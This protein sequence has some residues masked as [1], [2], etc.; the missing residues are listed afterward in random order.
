MKFLKLISA[1]VLLY[2]VLNPSEIKAQCAS[3][4]GF[5]NGNLS[6][7]NTSTDSLYIQPA[8]RV[9]TNPGI[10]S[11]IVS[12]GIT[13]AWLGTVNSPSSQ[14]GSYMVKVGNRGLRAVSDTVYRTFVIDSLSDKLTIYS[15][16]VSEIAHVF[17]NVP[18]N[19]SPGFGYEIYMNGKKVDC[20][21]GA[22]FTGNTDL[23]HVWDL[24][25]YKDTA[26]IR[27]STS[28]GMEVFNL[29]CFV[30]DTIEIRLFT[31]DCILL[32]HYAYAYFDVVCGDTSK[33]PISKITVKDVIQDKE[34]VL[35]CT[36]NATIKLEPL[37]ETCPVYMGNIK[38]TPANYI[39][40]P[41]NLDSAI[42]NV[43]DSAWIYAEAEF[44]N[45]CMSVTILDSI[46]VRY[47]PIDPHDNLPKI[48]KNFC[49]CD[50]DTIN[51]NGIKVTTIWDPSSATYNLNSSNRLV[52]SPCDR[53]TMNTTWKN[54]SANATSTG[55]AI[56]QSSW[57]SGN[58]GG[59]NTV[60]S[61]LP[62]GR[63][64][65][66]V[67]LITGKRMFLG[68][69]HNQSSYNNDLRHS[70]YINGN[71]ITAYFGT[72]AT[73]SS[74][75]FS[76]SIT[77]EFEVLSN[78]R[79]RIYINGSVFHNYTTTQKVLGPVFGD[80]SAQ[81]NF[82]PMVTST[83]ITGATKNK[84]QIS[85]L[86]NL[87][88][89]QY[90]LSY[91]DR[92]GTSTLDTITYTPG[93]TAA[94][95]TDIIQ[96]G[97]TPV[98]LGVQSGSLIDSITYS[99]INASGSFSP[100]N[101][102]APSRGKNL[103]YNPHF[104]D[105]NFKPM[106]VIF[107]SFSGRC[108]TKDTV[109]MTVNE[110]PGAQAGA[111]ITVAND[112]FILGDSPSGICNTCGSLQYIWSQGNALNDSTVANPVAYKYQIGAPYFVLK[113]N[114]SI[115]GCLNI[116][117]IQIFTTLAAEASFLSNNC[118]D[119]NTVEVRWK[120]APDKDIEAFGVEYSTDDGFTWQKLGRVDA[121]DPS[122]GNNPME[123][124]LQVRK[125][126][127]QYAIYRWFAISPTG[128]SSR[129]SDLNTLECGNGNAFTLFPN[130]F[131]SNIEVQYHS[132]STVFRNLTVELINQYGQIV[133]S[134]QVSKASNGLY[135]SIMLEHLD[136]LSSGIYQIQIRSGESVVFGN[137]IF[138]TQ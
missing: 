119:D 84:K 127:N 32:G 125:I 83:T 5:E 81:S 134:E 132:E 52:T 40:G 19:E 120:I 136:N 48:E 138:K 133:H 61:I 94:A 44:S 113:V 34:L 3:N 49:D 117:T 131:T 13:D 124:S 15:M 46:F 76:G 121:F 53:Y 38:W 106:K 108:K 10:N 114:D 101:N 41:R 58:N 86:N 95:V 80:I 98:T 55:S 7:W 100:N 110:I 77:V 57:T 73:T 128:Q 118:T 115:T 50:A 16:G 137:K 60:D 96:C 1:V 14:A 88:S 78:D 72:G 99:D 93:F 24:G 9:W 54:L 69:N 75:T 82:N 85:M 4:I 31:R 79:V 25:T 28:W 62:G 105:Y 35:Y 2:G 17:W 66:T 107:T 91:T 111:D 123:Y 37:V 42:V 102:G 6:S 67:S 59:G 47:S 21:K 12:Y 97:L 109:N 135:G 71:T 43:A 45:Y 56:G 87:L 126:E 26:G 11:S 103:L 104:S 23:P 36:T 27:K 122:Y 112:S 39:M 74:G 90:Y 8:N 129:H 18:V 89:H 63:I 33:P 130:P 64:K 68:I 70:V 65:Y 51:F 92:C 20:I 116:D 29:S 30:G 22:F